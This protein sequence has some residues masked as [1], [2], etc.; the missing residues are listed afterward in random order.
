LTKSRIMFVLALV[1]LTVGAV[2]LA[3]RASVQTKAPVKCGEFRW[4]V[5]T[6]SDWRAR[7][8][9]YTPKLRSIGF[10]RQFQAPDNLT[11]TTPRIQHSA[12]FVTYRLRGVRLLKAALEDDHDIHLVVAP[13]KA[14]SKTMIIEFPDVHCQ[15]AASSRKRAEI[16]DAR[17]ALLADCGTIGSSFVKL[18]GTAN[19]TGVGFFDSKHGQTGV[20]PNGIELHPA[21]RYS[22]GTCSKDTGGGGGGG[23]NNCT[24]GYSPCL[25]YHG[26]ADY[27]CY[28]GGGNG[29][30]YTAPGVVY[31]V[32]GSDPY[33]LDGDNDGL[34]CE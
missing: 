23:G 4:P 27:D 12:E 28:G 24:P 8:V 1:S 34:G 22:S 14:L 30:Y 11:G 9:N 2:A 6:L 26:G 25:V 31:Q 10:L 3:S 16:A 13:P 18:K 21:L 32:T 17:E 5:K 7:N 15:G 33:Q 19:I 29:P 20:A